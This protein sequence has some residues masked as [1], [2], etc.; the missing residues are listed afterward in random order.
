[1]K[2]LWIFPIIGALGLIGAAALQVVRISDET[3]MVA[4]TAQVIDVIDGCPT[5]E[6]STASGQPFEYRSR[7]CSKPPS[8]RRGD[9]VTLYYAA[10]IP[11]TRASI[12]SSVTGWA[13]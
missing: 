9:E 2:V 3:R 12:A 10:E 5:V 13:A 7:T 11:T 8:L 1:M 6:F 4:T